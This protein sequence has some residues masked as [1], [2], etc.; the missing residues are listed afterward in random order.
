[1]T[2]VPKFRTLDQDQYRFIRSECPLYDPSGHRLP[3]APDPF[4]QTTMPGLSLGGGN[5]TA[6]VF[7][8]IASIARTY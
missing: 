5:E 8:Y 1:M 2:I 7:I 6:G 3:Y 4:Q